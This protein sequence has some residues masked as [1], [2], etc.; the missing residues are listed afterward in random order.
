MEVKI[1]QSLENS[2]IL[3]IFLDKESHKLIYKSLYKKEL[4]KIRNFKD[5]STEFAA[6]EKKTAFAFCLNALSKRSYTK[7]ELEKEMKKRLISGEASQ[8][9]IERVEAYLDDESY[10]KRII[11]VLSHRG[12]GPQ[13]I[14]VQMRKKTDLAT[15]KLFQLIEENLPFE[16]QLEKAKELVR[17]KGPIQ[18]RKQQARVYR[19]LLS[20][21]YSGEI[22][23]KAV[24]GQ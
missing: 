5:F 2:R 13:A 9:A 3:E 16:S 24:Q 8:Y 15:P 22:A 12:K 10:L 18:D 19:F 14:F 23:Q 21:G 7:F 20:R 1:E 6:L 4:H 11:E 17:K